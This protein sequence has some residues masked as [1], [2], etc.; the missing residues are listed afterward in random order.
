MKTAIIDLGTNTFNLLIGE[1]KENSFKK[2]FETKRS[3]KLG[4][5]GI[6]RQII[7]SDALNRAINALKDFK[8][9]TEEYNVTEYHLIATSAIRN[10]KNK[11]ELIDK[12]KELFNWDVQVI[13]GDTEATLIYYGV[14][15]AVHLGET[16]KLIM[17]IGGGSTE[18][19]IANAHQIFWKK[20]YEIGAARLLEKFNPSDPITPNEIESILLYLNQELTELIT[21]AQLHRVSHLIGSSGSFD[22]F[23]DVIAHRYYNG[24]FSSDN[25][26]N[27]DFNLS[28]FEEVINLFITSNKVQRES[29]KGLISMRVD[30]IVIAS[31][32]IK[33]VKDKLNITHLSLSAYA[34]KEGVIYS[35]INKKLLSHA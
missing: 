13:D 23:A 32:M 20:S 25:I 28:E 9:I 21:N 26:L 12:I 30:M 8:Q 3:V 19:I 1:V 5:G 29:I 6:N 18:F 2:L 16:P 33:Y 34:L 7:L 14:K 15:Q 27:Y 31:V 35:I 22:S 10:A 17:D 11:K 4:E 24:K